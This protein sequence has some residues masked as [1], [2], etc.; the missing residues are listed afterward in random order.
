M[1][2]QYCQQSLK[3]PDL[4]CTEQQPTRPRIRAGKAC[5][6]CHDK[7]IKCDAMYQVPC[8][9]CVQGRNAHCVLR[10]TKRGTY[11][12]KSHRQGTVTANPRGG[13]KPSSPSNARVESEDVESLPLSISDA[14]IALPTATSAS[15]IAQN[16]LLDTQ[17][18]GPVQFG[19]GNSAQP[20]SGQESPTPRE[21]LFNRTSRG[22][23]ANGSSYRDISWSAM[24]DYFL[25]NREN[26]QDYIDKCSITYLGESF[27]L[28]FVLGHPPKLH[29]LGP[30]FPRAQTYVPSQTQ[31]THM[32]PE[33]LEYLRSKGVFNL[34]E[35][36]HLDTFI[37]V[38][39]DRV[40]PLYPIV[41]RQE[42]IQ[43]YK[44]GELPLI[45]LHA[46]SFM[47]VTFCS[48]S[49]LPLT[50]FT[51]RTE[52]RS[53][54][55]KKTKALFDMG[56][57][58]NK[59]IILQCTIILSFWGGG[60]NT[61]WNF[62]S[63]VSTAVTIAEA[64]GIHRSTAAVT[65]MQPQ[66]KSLMR[67]LW[68]MLVVRDSICGA[69]IGRPFRID[70]GQ[71][72]TDMLT[73]EDFAH[74]ACAPGFFA[75]PSRQQYAQYQV[76]T[77]KM[78]LIMRDI[79]ISRFHPGKQPVPSTVFHA[80]L[81]QWKMELTPSL[82]WNDD[83]PDYQ[84]PFSMSLSVQYNHHLILNSLG[85]LRG[86]HLCHKDEHERE[87]IVD[88]A[89]HNISTVMCTLVTKSS[90]LLVPHEIFH[91][92]FLAQAAFYTR[93]KSPNKLV[94][95]LG[96]SGLNSCQMVLQ[97]V[98]EFWDPGPFI[99]QLFD[100]LSARCSEKQLSSENES[101]SSGVMGNVEA[102]G[103]NGVIGSANEAGVF[104]ALLGDDRWQSNGMLSSLFDLPPELFLPE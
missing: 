90:L 60:P 94:A 91:G 83:T 30:P 80:K 58:T 9:P 78:S 4:G 53:F 67:R 1:V 86:A 14:T 31:P 47:A 100:N 66:D 69:L 48:Q 98:K 68:W 19:N 49:V 84:N 2:G 96:Q 65:N 59:I 54:F 72:D 79:I 25:N 40:Y 77:A 36:S 29:H 7:R 17:A 43:Q 39:L 104:N 73:I 74:D 64:I 52:A 56:Y 26:G 81:N 23:T 63:W 15:R 89:A 5:K 76:E 50:G 10:E 28:A 21:S 8:T 97:A 46:I 44:N 93:T 35:K 24:F 92:M 18:T 12:R 22:G 82:N 45:L 33:E 88:L 27:P 87:E 32:P 55:Y 103:S 61:Y 20:L 16:E 11:T 38:F 101:S 102:S 41:N 70:L 51:S 71:A 13:S 62:Y 37:S 6:L 85:H 34:P 57:E 95:R 3:M 99:M 75:D 42:L